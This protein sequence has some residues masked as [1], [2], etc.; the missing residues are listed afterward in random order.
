MPGAKATR[1]AQTSSLTAKE[2]AKFSVMDARWKPAKNT[3]LTHDP[4]TLKLL[5]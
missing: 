1:G 4:D 2:N 3:M 5:F